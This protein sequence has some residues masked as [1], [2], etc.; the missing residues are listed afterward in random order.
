MGNGSGFRTSGFFGMVAFGR[1]F[2][3]SRFENLFFRSFPTWSGIHKNHEV[4]DSRLRG[5]DNFILVFTQP[6]YTVGSG[7]QLKCVLPTYEIHY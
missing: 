3:C 1:K 5:N 7:I 4:L 6:L 2:G